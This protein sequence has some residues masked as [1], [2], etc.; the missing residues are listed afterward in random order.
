[1]D[2][3]EEAKKLLGLKKPPLHKLKW[4]LPEARFTFPV[5]NAENAV[6]KV[7]QTASFKSGGEFNDSILSKQYG[8]GVFAYFIVRSEKKTEQESLLFDGYMIQE[9]EPLG[10]S[11]Q[12]GYST[13]ESLANIGYAPAF[14]RTVTEWRFANIN[15]KAAVFEIDGFGAF[16]EFAL[17]QTDLEKTREIQT[18]AFELAVKKIGLKT[19]EALPTDVITLQMLSMQEQGNKKNKQAEFSLGK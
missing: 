11:L 6:A 3:L 17:P 15:F 19:R 9:D 1:M 2:L 7:R 14:N 5:K 16:I 12:S 4:K 13:Q 10:V 8:E 18:K